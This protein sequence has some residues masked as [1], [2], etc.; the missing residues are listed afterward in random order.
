M[1]QTFGIYAWLHENVA[2]LNPNYEQS[3]LVIKTGLFRK[4]HAMREPML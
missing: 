3:K 4:N 1:I 2:N